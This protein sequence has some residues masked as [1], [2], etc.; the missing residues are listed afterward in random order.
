MFW[1]TFSQTNASPMLTPFGAYSNGISERWIPQTS[2]LLFIG[3]ASNSADG[4]FY[5]QVFWYDTI[6]NQV[7]QLTTDA[8]NKN[9]AFLFQAPN[10]NDNYIFFTISGTTEIDVYE[11]T[12]R[13]ATGAPILSLV[14]RIVS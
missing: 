7:A 4:K 5:Q 10:F 13:S 11:M 8:T 9:N 14:N 6:S 2:E 12:G 1:E 3:T